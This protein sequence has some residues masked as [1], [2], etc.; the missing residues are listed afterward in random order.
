MSLFYFPFH[1]PDSDSL[2]VLISVAVAGSLLIVAGF[3]I[4]C[5][6]WKC[7]KIDEQVQICE[8]EMTCVVMTNEPKLHERNAHASCSS[9]RSHFSLKCVSLA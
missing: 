7:R 9:I 3:G 1:P 8:D 4:F 5:I 6:Y 2:T